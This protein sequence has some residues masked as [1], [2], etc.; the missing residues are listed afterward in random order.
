MGLFVIS[1]YLEITAPIFLNL[2]SVTVSFRKQAYANNL[3]WKFV[4]VSL[5]LNLS[6]PKFP[7]NTLPF[8]FCLATIRIK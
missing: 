7:W 5:Q 6:V 1:K 3:I 2:H 8:F 4:F